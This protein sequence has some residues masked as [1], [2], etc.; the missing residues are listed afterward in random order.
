M[1]LLDEITTHDKDLLF[2]LSV[3]RDIKA[4]DSGSV[5]DGQ[6]WQRK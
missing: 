6:T 3:S 4:Y 1:H 2:V 5:M